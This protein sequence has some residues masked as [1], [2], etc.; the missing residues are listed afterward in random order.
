MN[1]FSHIIEDSRSDCNVKFQCAVF[2]Y[3]AI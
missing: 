2:M 3:T 1:T